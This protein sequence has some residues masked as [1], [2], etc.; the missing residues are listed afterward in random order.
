[1]PIQLQNERGRLKIGTCTT[2]LVLLLSQISA[3]LL[4]AQNSGAGIALKNGKWFEDGSFRTREMYIVN[5]LLSE[6]APSSVAEVVDFN[7]QFVIPPLGDAHEH[8]FN[9]K[10]W[11]QEDIRLFLNEGVFY[12]MV[13]D[14]IGPLDLE[15]RSQV[16]HQRSVDVAYT[17]AP[18]IGP[19]HGL[20][21]LFQ[22]MA[23][24]PP[25]EKATS[26]KDL[27]TIAYFL[28]SNES[29]V[30]QKWPAL[31]TKNIDFVKVI[32]AFSEEHQK[33]REDEKFYSDT[34]LNMAR[35]GVPPDLLPEIVSRSHQMGRPV[36]V[37]VET[38][39]D[40]RIAV[41]AGAD[42]IAHLPGWHV[43]PTAG[44]EDESLEHWL[45]TEEDAKAAAEKNVTV[46]TTTYPKPFLDTKTHA[47]KY[48]TVQT[49]NLEQLKKHGV[50]VAI[51]ADNG[52]VTSIAEAEHLLTLKVFNR[53]EL[54]QA[55][56]EI[57]PRA[58]FPKRKIGCL[59]EG[60]E[61]SFLV[62]SADPLQDLSNLRK[63]AMRYKN[64][65]RLEQP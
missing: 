53:S 63:I 65:I 42:M 32:L 34:K 9:S 47:D 4:L 28:M 57:T 29:D 46:V 31:A 13:Q 6:K 15:V 22:S 12:V 39:A 51:G 41:A 3:Y 43:G 5:G 60:C 1:M 21:D 18:L 59:Q 23:G 17:W 19:G 37:H 35:P 33:R 56:V 52:Q 45:I 64:G 44:F 11:I 7:A 2:L 50:P 26:V 16:N 55:L 49:R 61:A 24:K 10:R 38:A 25:F 20:L 40:F 27:D 58:I 54:L 30:Q 14:S 62:L 8:N 36:S 48:R